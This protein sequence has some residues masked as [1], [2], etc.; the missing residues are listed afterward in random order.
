MN[1]NKPSNKPEK[2]GKKR[3]ILLIIVVAALVVIAVVVAV[4]PNLLST[5]SGQRLVRSQ[6]NQHLPGRADFSNL[7]LGWR[8]GLDV[9]DFTFDSDQVNLQID[10]ITA[11]IYYSSL[12]RGQASL[13]RTVLVRPVAT[14]ELEMPDEPDE[15]LTVIDMPVRRMDLFIQDGDVSLMQQGSLVSQAANLNS[16]IRVRPAGSTSTL[17]LETTVGRASQ[18]GSLS[19]DAEIT[20]AGT[21]TQ[22]QL[23]RASGHFT[24]DVNDIDLRAVEGFLQLAGVELEM[25]GNISGSVSSSVEQGRVRA[26]DAVLDGQDLAVTGE[27]MAGDTFSTQQLAVDVSLDMIEDQLVEIQRFDVRGDWF[28]ASAVGVL[29]M[30]LDSLED[31]LQSEQAQLE[32]DF[33]ADAAVAANQ[34]RN[35]LA[36]HENIQINAGRIAGTAGKQQARLEARMELFDLQGMLEDQ[37]IALDEPIRALAAIEAVEDTIVYEQLSLESDFA[38]INAAGAFDALDYDARIDLDRLAGQIGQFIWADQVQLAGL[39]E[40][41]GRAS[42]GQIVRLDGSLA[43]QDM[44]LA[45]D[46]GTVSDQQIRLE[47]RISLDM[48]RDI[49]QI[50]VLQLESD[51]AR[52]DVREAFVSFDAP[53]GP[54]QA[55]I[56]L[57]FDIAQAGPWLALAGVDDG[58]LPRQARLDSRLSLSA[59]DNVLRVTTDDT[60][61]EDLTIQAIE[62]PAIVEPRVDIVFDGRYN[63]QTG[64]YDLQWDVAGTRHLQT[65]GALSAGAENE[66]LNMQGQTTI[67]YDWQVVPGLIGPFWPEGLVIEG[68]REDRFDFS[69]TYSPT[70]EGDL[71]ANLTAS[72]N[73]GFD[74]ASFMGLVAGPVDIG[75]AFD[76]GLMNVEPFEM[77]VNEGVVSLAGQADFS[78]EPVMFVLPEP[79][80][81]ARDIS[82]NEEV[83]NQLLQYVNP[84]FAGTVRASGLAGFECRRLVMPLD[85]ELFE[86]ARMEGTISVDQMQLGASGLL[87]VIFAAIAGEPAQQRMTLHPTDIILSENVI[88]Y[89]DMQLDVGRNPV[90]FSGSVNIASEAIDMN[91]LLP[92]TTTGQTVRVDRDFSGRRISI[93]MRGTIGDPDID[94]AGAIGRTIID[95]ALRRGLERLFP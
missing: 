42:I 36:L 91:V 44:T 1:E 95:D 31:F 82:I 15:P 87:N 77:E 29:P 49:A 48:A 12:L 94:V 21:G 70:L 69:S 26:V 83:T 54:M 65:Q 8:S 9:R 38:R 45:I 58:L 13:G 46:R 11:D 88:S 81:V 35:T 72:G 33:Q 75:L 40:A 34:F 19:A 2:H 7:S 6:L 47:H 64:A 84:V 18:P 24:V 17:A 55:D 25:T 57:Q 30:T 67:A 20:P 3:R 86:Q 66:Q 10:R 92:Y 5:G 71:M 37:R 53:A 41:Q 32:A 14:M 56:D 16:R 23:G 63:S 22:W 51:M 68:R 93:P 59:A 62:G 39:V 50:D 76:Q 60:V 61:I 79:M 90:N 27:Q 43:V 74:Q 4:L 28:S 89:Q 85:F 80:T 52:I 78:A 73:V